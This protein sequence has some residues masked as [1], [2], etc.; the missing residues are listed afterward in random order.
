MT[1]DTQDTQ[2]RQDAGLNESTEAATEAATTEA[3]G[4]APAPA[5]RAGKQVKAR[6][7]VDCEHGRVNDVA[8]LSEAV[9]KSA[10][11]AGLVDTHKDAVAYAL[12]LKQA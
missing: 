10:Q 4:A 3:A 5:P 7:L 6:V 9:A 11:A 8:T 12:S 1:P 2:A